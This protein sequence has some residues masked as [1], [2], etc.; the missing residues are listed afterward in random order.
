MAG[1]LLDELRELVDLMD[2]D[3][4]FAAFVESPMVDASQRT[5]SIETLFRNKASDLLVDS[6]QVLNHKGRLQIL[7]TLYAGYREMHNERV[8]RIDVHVT[9]AVPLTAK[10]RKRLIAQVAKDREG[11][12][13]LLIETVDESIIGGMVVRIA[14]RKIDASVRREI[15]GL[16]DLLHWRATHII[17][18]ERLVAG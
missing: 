11:K 8:D 15:H 14:D 5:A 12:E 9:T 17:H 16:R 6:L 7:P 18:A 3:E 13:A 10:V 1:E 2:R 4:V